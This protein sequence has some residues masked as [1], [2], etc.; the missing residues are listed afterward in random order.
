[1]KIDEITQSVNQIAN[2]EA[3]L[4]KKT[5]QEGKTPQ[6]KEQVS[7]PGEKIDLSNASVEFSRT[8][9]MVDKAPEIRAEKVAE[10]RELVKSGKYNVESVKIADK[11]LED[12]LADIANPK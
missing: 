9:E 7:Q 4:N 10:L 11:I 3:S 5:E 6:G 12:N 2:L 1:M 8:A